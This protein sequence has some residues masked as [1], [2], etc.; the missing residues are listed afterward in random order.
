MNKSI[1]IL[2]HLKSIFEDVQRVVAAGDLGSTRKA[3][4]NAKG[5][6]VKWFDLAADESVCAYLRKHFPCSV[7]LLSEEGSPPE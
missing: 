4:R 2:N 7:V 3:T 6:I 5:D 1:S